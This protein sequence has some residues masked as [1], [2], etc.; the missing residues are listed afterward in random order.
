[1]KTVQSSLSPRFQQSSQGPTEALAACYC[2]FECFLS[3]FFFCNSKSMLTTV[4]AVSLPSQAKFRD[5]ILELYQ[6]RLSNLELM[7]STA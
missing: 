3:L 2:V 1:M 5:G 7:L 6:C 4:R